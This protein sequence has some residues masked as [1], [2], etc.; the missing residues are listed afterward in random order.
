MKVATIRKTAICSY[1][2]L[3]ITYKTLENKVKAGN[4]IN[5]YMHTIC[6]KAKQ[7]NNDKK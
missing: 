1:C 3:P 7:K 4:S 2:G 5:G 6:T